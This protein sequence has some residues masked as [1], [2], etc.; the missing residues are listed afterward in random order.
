MNNFYGMPFEIFRTDTILKESKRPV[1]FVTKGGALPGYYSLI[2]M[3]E[4]Y[5]L[6]ITLLVG[7]DHELLIELE[8]IVTV[9]LVQHAENAIWHGIDA[10]YAT[11]YSS[12]DPSLN[13]SVELAA[14]ASTGLILNSF[15]SNGTDVFES[16]IP[17]WVGKIEGPDQY[18]WRIQLVPTYL[19]KNETTQQGEIWRM[20]VA[21]GRNKHIKRKVWDDSCLA[22]YDAISYA[23]LP[24]TEI[25][26]WHE[27]G[28]V[29]LPAWQVTMKAEDKG[30]GLLVQG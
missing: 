23:G 24:V 30:E 16:L 11:R 26:F 29:E 7:G 10:K 17:A 27:R 1:T 8:E 4:E 9:E 25:V 6:G 2:L 14:S 5:G 22:D 18:P 15:I 19:Y 21:Y 3:L 12:V 28:L 13:S 20:T